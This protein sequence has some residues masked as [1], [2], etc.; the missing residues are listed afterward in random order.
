MIRDKKQEFAK[1]H[2]PK[3]REYNLEELIEIIR[4]EDV[5]IREVD[6]FYYSELARIVWPGRLEEERLYKEAKEGYEAARTKYW[7]Q[8]DQIEVRILD[9]A[10]LGGD[11]LGLLE[12]FMDTVNKIN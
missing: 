10:I 5:T 1:A 3:K 12:E 9:R 11:L 4:T 7:V 6:G 8:L 2:A